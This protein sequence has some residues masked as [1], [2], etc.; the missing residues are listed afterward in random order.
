[1]TAADQEGS[2]VARRRRDAK[3]SRRR[4]LGVL[5]ATLTAAAGLAGSSGRLR[6]KSGHPPTSGV[7]LPAPDISVTTSSST[8][9]TTTTTTRAPKKSTTTRAAQA[10]G[11]RPR[12]GP[13]PFPRS[14]YPTASTVALRG[15]QTRQYRPDG[16]SNRTFDLTGAVWNSSPLSSAVMYPIAIDDGGSN[17]PNG[18]NTILKGARINGNLNLGRFRGDNYDQYHS[19]IEHN[20]DSDSGYV[21][22]DRVRVHN[23]MDGYRFKGRGDGY[24]KRCWFSDISDD[25]LEFEDIRGNVF[26]YDCLWE[27]VTAFSDR[28]GSATP[29]PSSRL[30]VDGLLCWIKPQK[31]AAGSSSEFSGCS[32]GAGEGCG[33]LGE[34][35]KCSFAIWKGSSQSRPRIVV[36]N[37]WFRIDRL[38]CYGASSMAWPGGGLTWGSGGTSYSYRNVKVL[39]TGLNVAGRPTGRSYP[40]PRLPSGVELV[41]GAKALDMWEGAVA[42]W[43]DDHGYG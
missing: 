33:E 38:S 40:G 6:A 28:D 10:A 24:L 14:G 12:P 13:E 11:N 2:R 31:D 32:G 26:V 43:K 1:V 25:A 3:V 9:T 27:C 15:V 8:S 16:V 30:E 22:A 4:F 5:A 19:G 20:C 18:H 29:L 36:R 21:I 17:T 42:A 34:S 7:A 35:G 39:W 23:M 37:S 41:T